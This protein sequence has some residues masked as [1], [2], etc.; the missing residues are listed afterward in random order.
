MD[1]G[2][3]ATKE[4]AE[5]QPSTTTHRLSDTLGSSKSTIHRHLTALGKIYRSCRVVSHELTV[6]QAQQQLEFCHKL[7]QLLKD[8]RFIKRIVNCD[9]KWIYL[10]NPNLQKQWLDKGPVPVPKRGRSEKKRLS[11]GSGGT[12]KALFIMNLC[13][14]AIRSTRRYILNN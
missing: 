5:Q 2:S 3:E 10:N 6:K 12:T 14:T 7:L 1:L 13:Q 4:A 8:H 11:S 9:E